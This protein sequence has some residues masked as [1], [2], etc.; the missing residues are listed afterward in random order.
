MGVEEVFIPLKKMPPF[1]Q[2]LLKDGE[3]K[4]LKVKMEQLREV[5]KA[6]LKL[7]SGRKATL[8]KD[9]GDM[10]SNKRSAQLKQAVDVFFEETYPRQKVKLKTYSKQ[11]VVEQARKAHAL[12][13][14]DE[15]KKTVQLFLINKLAGDTCPPEPSTHVEKDADRLSELSKDLI[16]AVQFKINPECPICLDDIP[17]GEAAQCRHSYGPARH[18]FHLTCAQDLE[19]RARQSGSRR[20]A[21]PVCRFEMLRNFQR[22]RIDG[23]EIV[24]HSPDPVHPISLAERVEGIV[25]PVAERILVPGSQVCL[26]LLVLLYVPVALYMFSTTELGQD[27]MEIARPFASPWIQLG[28]TSLCSSILPSSIPSLIKWFACFLFISLLRG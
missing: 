5:R 21:C 19:G 13:V 15:F 28:A 18:I 27:L 25:V 2:E 11:E 17:S 8:A 23:E 14:F 24:S 22:I 26:M 9:I 7:S 1:F 4:G 3:V 12:S 20:V 6:I 16:K 10:F